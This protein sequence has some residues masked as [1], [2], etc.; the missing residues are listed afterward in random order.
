MLP[1]G[2]PWC[3]HHILSVEI[4]KLYKHIILIFGAVQSK[5]KIK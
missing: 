2:L 5:E 3:L 4:I 1:F